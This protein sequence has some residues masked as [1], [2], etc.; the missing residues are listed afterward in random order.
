MAIYNR[1]VQAL[2]Q[3]SP[4]KGTESPFGKERKG[5]ERNGKERKGTE[6]EPNHNEKMF[7]ATPMASDSAAVRGQIVARQCRPTVL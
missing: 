1:N 5:T 6:K 4:K 2:S 3:F 7:D